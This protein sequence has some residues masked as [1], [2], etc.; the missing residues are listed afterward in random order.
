MSKIITD[1]NILVNQ[2]KIEYKSQYVYT[3]CFE[4]DNYQCPDNLTCQKENDTYYCIDL[5]II[6]QEMHIMDNIQKE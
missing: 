5:T 6:P 1:I 3:P 4:S 2:L